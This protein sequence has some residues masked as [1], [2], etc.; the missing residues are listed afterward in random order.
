LVRADL[1]TEK[2]QE[3]EHRVGRVRASCPATADGLRADENAL[4]LVAFNLMLAVQICADIAGHAI[5]D[6]GWRTAVTLAAAFERLAEHG[7]ISAATARQ[8]GNASHFRN[9]VAHGYA[10][11]DVDKAFAAATTGVVD[12]E[13]FGRE[14]AAWLAARGP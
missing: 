11:L 9:I 12:L 6:E 10:G 14:I 4:D 7:A 13:S 8:L 2:L 3:L 1:V 5:A